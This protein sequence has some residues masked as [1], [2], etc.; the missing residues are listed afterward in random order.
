MPL[1]PYIKY[2]KEKEQYYQTFFAEEIGS[3]A[4]PTASLHFTPELVKQ[5]N[6]KKVNF[7]YLCL[8][9]GL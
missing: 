8:H 3:A 6:D 4:A 5:L 1:P 7:K 9:V 2:E